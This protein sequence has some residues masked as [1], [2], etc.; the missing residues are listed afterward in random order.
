[1]AYKHYFLMC[2]VHGVDELND[3]P[4]VTSASLD[5]RLGGTTKKKLK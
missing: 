3:F 5:D 4:R 2:T 1:M